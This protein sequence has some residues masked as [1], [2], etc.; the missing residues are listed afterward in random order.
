M[1]DYL[2]FILRASLCVLGVLCGFIS[3]CIICM[4]AQC[5]RDMK[6]QRTP[7]TQREAQRNTRLVGR[8]LGIYWLGMN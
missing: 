7:S 5:Q 1:L 6:P 8:V 2:K 3:A 4:P